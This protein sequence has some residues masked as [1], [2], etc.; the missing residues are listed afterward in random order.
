MTAGESL[1]SHDIPYLTHDDT[2]TEVQLDLVNQFQ[3]YINQSPHLLQ[4][5]LGAFM[6][7][8][9]SNTVDFLREN[10]QEGPRMLALWDKMIATGTDIEFEYDTTTEE[11]IDNDPYIQELLKNRNRFQQVQSPETAKEQTIKIRLRRLEI[12][13]GEIARNTGELQPPINPSAA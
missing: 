9:R 10:D 11:K 5:S 8:S 3:E 7:S 13:M 4:Q 2:L 6:A 12:F 1:N